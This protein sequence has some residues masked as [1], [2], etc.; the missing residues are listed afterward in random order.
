VL[1]IA[2]ASPFVALIKIRHIHVL[3]E[4][5]GTV[6]I[7]PRVAAELADPGRPESVRSFI[8]HPPDWL[9]IRRPVT[10]E[11]IPKLHPGELDA[12]SLALELK[13]D[14][15]VIDDKDGRSAAIARGLTTIRTAALLA[16]AADRGLIDLQQAF[17]EL[18]GTNFRI[19]ADVLDGLLQE[20][21]ERRRR[22][23]PGA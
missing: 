18:R 4:L 15:L 8:D 11:L 14:L 7:P 12:I 1:V 17:D 9:I 2:D 20:H 3:P 5:F 6:T 16:E 10:T 21:H 19:S 13:A 23:M 22:Q